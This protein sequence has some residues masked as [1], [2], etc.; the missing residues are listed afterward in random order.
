MYSVGYP[1]T[2]YGYGGGDFLGTLLAL[3]WLVLLGVLIAIALR[4][5]RQGPQWFSRR[6]ESALSILRE[7][8]ARG[9]I[10]HDEF[11]QKKKDLSV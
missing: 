6:S 7:R 2:G 1:M 5:L 10:D 8:Y 9:E 11:E 3:F 4:A